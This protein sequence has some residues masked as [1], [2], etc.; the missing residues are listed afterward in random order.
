[1]T[2]KPTKTR[3]PKITVYITKYALTQGVIRREVEN[4]SASGGC[5]HFKDEHGYMEFH[6]ESNWTTHPE[7]AQGRF[8]ELRARKI[9][10]LEKQL[11]KLKKQTYKLVDKAG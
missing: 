7:V 6:T 11:A 10:N 9:T 5:L 4:E 8:E 3:H 2:D 1:M